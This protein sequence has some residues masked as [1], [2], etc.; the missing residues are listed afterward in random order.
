MRKGWQVGDTLFPVVDLGAET[1]LD[2]VSEPRARG[3][4]GGGMAVE[5]APSSGLARPSGRGWANWEEPL[6]APRVA[7]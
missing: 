4:P 1:T 2:A 5:L 7:P 6:E 3:W